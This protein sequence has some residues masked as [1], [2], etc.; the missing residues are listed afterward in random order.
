MSNF[1][2]TNIGPMD[3]WREHFGGFVPETSRDGR[4]V[5]DHELDTEIIGF[6]ATA[7]EP[8]EEAG[9]W[10]SHSTLEEVYVFLE[11][12]GQMGLDDQV[13][14]VHPGTVVHVGTGVMRTWR[15]LP[16][17]PAQLRWLCL[18]AGQIPLPAIPD[19]AIPIRDIPM[20]W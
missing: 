2:V 9:Y 14:D 3:S 16:D 4:R 18:R 7:Y 17:S 19:D 12:E 1:S 10:H 15:A 13:I 11:G 20:P 5:V 8:G 6:T